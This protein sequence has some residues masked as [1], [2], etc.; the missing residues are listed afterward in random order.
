MINEKKLRRM[1]LENSVCVIEE[2]ILVYA[3]RLKNA[4]NARKDLLNK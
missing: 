3:G 1:I 2:D 4:T